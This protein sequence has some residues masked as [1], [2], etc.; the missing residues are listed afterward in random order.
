MPSK[1]GVKGNIHYQTYYHGWLLGLVRAIDIGVVHMKNRVNRLASRNYRAKLLKT[2]RIQG[3]IVHMNYGACLYMY[4][5]VNRV[6]IRE[7]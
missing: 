4:L 3:S 7:R 1:Y 5:V 6:V 2:N